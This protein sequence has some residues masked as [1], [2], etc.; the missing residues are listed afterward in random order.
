[1]AWADLGRRRTGRSGAGAGGEDNER[2]SG[3]GG[4]ISPNG[5]G[6]RR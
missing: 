2:K 1:M 4:G 5:L 6:A 3:G